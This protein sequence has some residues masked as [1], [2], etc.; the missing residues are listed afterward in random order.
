M[1]RFSACKGPKR[2]RPLSF[3]EVSM[4]TGTFFGHCTHPPFVQI[5]E[6]PEF[7]EIVKWGKFALAQVLAL[8]WVVTC[9]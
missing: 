5:W 6:S 8:A 1:E 4:V 9:A 7:A 2:Q 3:V